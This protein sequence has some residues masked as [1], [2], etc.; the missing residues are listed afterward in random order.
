M[1]A[2]VAVMGRVIWWMARIIRSVRHLRTAW[3]SRATLQLA[4]F[5]RS[6]GALS[7]GL[8]VCAGRTVAL[9]YTGYLLYL[10]IPS[11]LISTKRKA[12]ASLVRRWR[13]AC[14]TGS[15]ARPNRYTMGLRLSFVQKV[16]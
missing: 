13:L 2:G 8:V 10:G 4:V 9:F 7:T 16:L 12:L 1:L 15:A 11:F 3:F 6:G 5:K 14:C